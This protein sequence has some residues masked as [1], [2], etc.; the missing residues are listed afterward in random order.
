MVVDAAAAVFAVHDACV[1]VIVVA[2]TCS[3][4]TSTVVIV[5]VHVTHVVAVKI[6][7]LYII[8]SCTQLYHFFPVYI[9]I[10]QPLR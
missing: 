6:L 10:W 9:L 2:V 5:F 1:V 4:A 3:V 8:L 7:N